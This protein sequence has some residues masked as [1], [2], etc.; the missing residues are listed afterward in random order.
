MVDSYHLVSTLIG[1][2]SLF[3]L[4]EEIVLCT[5]MLGMEIS[6]TLN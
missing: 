3:A 4:G 6:N 2:V 5:W 1:G